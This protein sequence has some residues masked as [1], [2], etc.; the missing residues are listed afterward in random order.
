[1]KYI[2]DAK[3][4]IM[5]DLSFSIQF[6]SFADIAIFVSYILIRLAMHLADHHF[7]TQLH[8]VFQYALTCIEN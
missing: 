4:A 5:P 7:K 1:M 3:S 8:I 2:T 6:I